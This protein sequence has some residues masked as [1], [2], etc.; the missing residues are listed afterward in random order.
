MTRREVIQRLLPHKAELRK[1]GVSSLAL[2][3]STARDDSAAKS[4][5][6][7]LIEFDRSISL[8]HFF[9][10][11]HKLEEILGVSRIDLV[12]RGALHPALRNHILAEAVD[13]A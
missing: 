12:E 11:Q 10:V 1:M 6:D 7:L 13:V 5:V 4:D 3:G 8:F 9:R 2:F